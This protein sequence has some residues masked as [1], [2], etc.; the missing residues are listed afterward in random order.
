MSSCPTCSCLSCPDHSRVLQGP[1]H[2]HLPLVA[3][4]RPVGADRPAAAG[5]GQQR[6]Q[7]RKTREVAPPPGAG[8]RLLRRTRRYPLA[9]A[10]G[11][12]PAGWAPSTAS[13]C[14]SAAPG[15]EAGARRPARAGKSGPRARPVPTA[16]VTGSQSVQGSHTVPRA[17]RGYDAGKRTN[18]RKRHLAVD[19]NGL[20]LTVLVTAAGVQDRDGA[21]RLLTDLKDRFSRVRGVGRRRLRRPSGGPG[22]AGARAGRRDRQA[23]PGHQRVP[24]P[25][26]EWGR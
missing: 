18:G 14:A 7:G 4:R 20:V 23:L 10:P 19:T 15:V 25:E 2:P 8:R 3:E 6:R 17:C 1:G 26:Q 13:S 21:I 24:G 9:R 22:R 11:R 5:T 12:L 16:A